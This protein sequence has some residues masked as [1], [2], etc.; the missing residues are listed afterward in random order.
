MLMIYYSYF[1][2]IL[3]DIN[4]VRDDE[5]VDFSTSH[6]FDHCDSIFEELDR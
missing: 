5:F 4:L 2:N 1:K 6:N 3:N